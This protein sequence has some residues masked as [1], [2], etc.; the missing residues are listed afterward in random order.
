[1]SER[2]PGGI[3]TKS[4]ATPTGPYQ[5]GTAPG[6]WTLEQQLQ[7]QQQGVWPTAGLLPNYI[8]DVFS[9][10]L[11]TGTGAAQTITNNIDLST[12]GGLVWLKERNNARSHF[13]Q[14]SARTITSYL[15]SDNTDAASSGTA[16]TALNTTGFTLGT[17]SGSN[18][19]GNTYV[20]WSF[21]EQ[22][23]FFDVVTYTG[24]GAALI[25]HNLGS[26]PG[27]I[28]VKCTSNSGTEWAV[29]HR[30]LGATKYILLNQTDAEATSSAPWNN[31]E[32]TSTNFSV[33][34][35]S[36]TG[37]TGRTYVA[38][39]FAHDAGGFGLTGTDNVISCGSFNYNTDPQTVTIGYE[40][41]WLMVKRSDGVGD[42]IMFDNMRGFTANAGG[43]I[44]K[45]LLANTSGAETA[46][47]GLYYGGATGFN[48][49]L[50][51]YGN[52]IYITIRRGPMKVP[53]T[54]TSVF[55]PST[56]AGTGAT[57]TTSNLS[58]P[59]DMVWSKGR[60]NGGTNSGDF[61]R[62]RA[63]TRQL[64]LNQTD[65]E[66]TA[67]TS[68][69]GFDVM[70]GYAAGADAVQLT[71]NASGYN[72]VNWQFRRAPGFFDEVC[73]TGNQTARTI[74]HNL[75]AAPELMITKNRSSA[76]F[77][78]W[79]TCVPSIGMNNILSL[80]TSGAIDTGWSS[81]FTSTPP[82]SSVFSL[83]SGQQRNETGVTY[84]AYLFATCAGVSKVG[85]YTGT[86]TTLQ[87]DCGFTAGS[88]FVLIKRTDT[89][90][91]WYVWDSARG[92]IAGND[93]YLLLNSTAAE[94]TGTDY[95]DTY[96]A[97]FEIS[98]TAPSAI[99]AN[100]GT[101]IFLAIA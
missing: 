26:V 52:Y 59:P 14:D 70:T 79:L 42:W 74:S 96:A 77:T 83:S 84:V 97:G 7:F 9:T 64:S 1:M 25:P 21:R 90:G 16:V 91:D 94:V 22:P 69:T 78:A 40:P 99:N 100:G 55:T 48:L 17:Q 10:Y 8:E 81:P 38:Y 63:A 57:A 30:S 95:V 65:A 62:L 47:D 87:I 67:S 4:P 15:S 35:S 37:Q 2:Y 46:N 71:I 31:T 61:D 58:F 29:Y 66:T 20:S 24:S 45:R 3:I 6:I 56:R 60:D 33:G 89:T 41:Q 27:T 54:G 49:N 98:S 72:Y 5:T 32:P 43:G 19:S 73:Y 76:G 51:A 85:S 88:R 12:K 53:T 80:N 93:P 82:T 34:S 39:L 101:F 50:P 13:L 44:G 75:A 86:G 68:L 18:G 28:I 36:W 23:K 11:Y 92:I